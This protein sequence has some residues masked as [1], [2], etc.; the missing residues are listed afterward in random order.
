VIKLIGKQI[1]KMDHLPL[2]VSVSA[3]VVQIDEGYDHELGVEWKV[4][5]HKMGEL[6]MSFP[7]MMPRQSFMV[8]VAK[9]G[10]HILDLSLAALEN[11]GHGRVVAR[12]HLLMENHKEA[13]IE[14][15]DLVPYESVSDDK[16]NVQFK[17]AALRLQ[18]TP[19]IFSKKHITLDLGVNHDKVSTI[20]V[21]GKP[22]IQTQAL[23]TQVVVSSGQTVV[24]GGIYQTSTEAGQESIPILGKLPIF[25]QLFRLNTK[26]MHRKELLIFLTPTLMSV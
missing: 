2:Q 8:S 5:N 10:D 24:L 14:A 7:S 22:I 16:V 23:H 18:V 17:K 25:G 26:K 4:R 13:V 1:P 9:F 19:T 15:G 12:P 21:S 20:Q 6:Q 3:R 11:R